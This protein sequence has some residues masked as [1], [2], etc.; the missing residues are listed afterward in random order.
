MYET[1]NEK[2]GD[3]RTTARLWMILCIV[4]I[5]GVTAGSAQA[6]INSNQATVA[7]NLTQP[8]TLTVSVSP[9][10][11]SQPGFDLLGPAI[12]ISVTAS[13]AQT[14]TVTTWAYWN[15]PALTNGTSTVSPGNISGTNL[16]GGIPLGSFTQAGPFS[17]NSLQLSSVSV[18]AGSTQLPTFNLGLRVSST[19]LTIVPGTYSGTLFIQAQAI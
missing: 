15:N 4:A 2:G 18:T 13:L 5:L 12:S 16:T 1:E 9:G 14:R 6:Q 19:G 8:E 7:V 11:I 17:S 3:M 10:S